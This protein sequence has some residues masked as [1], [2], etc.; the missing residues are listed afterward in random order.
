MIGQQPTGLEPQSKE[1]WDKVIHKE[2]RKKFSI[3][4]LHK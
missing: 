2:V 3:T 4:V 1:I